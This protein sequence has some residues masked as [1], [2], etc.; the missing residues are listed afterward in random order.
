MKEYFVVFMAECNGNF[1]ENDIVEFEE[2]KVKED[3]DKLESFL[4]HRWFGD[5]RKLKVIN[6]REV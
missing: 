5:E 2:I 6:F 4:K 3:I 1:P